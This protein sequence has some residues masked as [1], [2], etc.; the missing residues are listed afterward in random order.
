LIA[1]DVNPAN[2]R[3]HGRSPLD[4]LARL[5]AA[6]GHYRYS[7]TSDQTPVWVTGQTLMAAK[8]QA[9]PLIRVP[10]SSPSGGAVRAHPTHPSSTAP[11]PASGSGVTAPSGSSFG[12]GQS[13]ANRGAG[14]PRASKARPGSRDAPS[15]GSGG[16]QANAASG[17]AEL[18]SSRSE[19]GLSLA[20]WLAGA[21]G[22]LVAGL[23]GGFI[24]Y[25]R[26]L[27]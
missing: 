7:A 1:A 20:L 13:A 10:R 24:W 2:L 8:G 15:G 17:P 4:Y 21:F 9:L 18:A 3:A 22:L 27:P 25:R 26:R 19:G 12:G 14:K 23:G 11:T 5:K 16:Q 6:D